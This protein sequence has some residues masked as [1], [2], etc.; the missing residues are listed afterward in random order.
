MGK[1]CFPCGPCRG[2]ILKTSG[3]TQKSQIWDSKIR[4]QVP[5]DYDRERLRW[6]RPAAHTKERP[7]PSSERASHGMRNVTVRR[8]PYSERKKYLV[9]SPRCGSTPRLT[10]WLT[11]SRNVTLTL[12]LTQAVLGQFSKSFYWEDF[13]VSCQFRSVNRRFYVWYSAE[14]FTEEGSAVYLRL[15]KWQPQ[16]VRYV[17]N[18]CGNWRFYLKCVIQ[19]DWIRE[20]YC[21]ESEKINA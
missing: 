6:Q 13:A 21:R 20:D 10:D 3:T 17:K 7:V 18:Y 15:F 12:T 14:S 4:S 11:V 16:E 8:I 5:R 9:T 19:W 1:M 2:V